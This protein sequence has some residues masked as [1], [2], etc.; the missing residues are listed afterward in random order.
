[1]KF[2]TFKQINHNYL[3]YLGQV[4]I[5]RY[6]LDLGF[7]NRF[8]NGFTDVMFERAADELD[9]M[10][11]RQGPFFPMFQTENAKR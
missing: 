5:T 3:A 7:L 11:E 4:M 8:V 9:D 10:R 2:N 6:P 1:M